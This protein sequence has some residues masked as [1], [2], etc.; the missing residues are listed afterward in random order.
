MRFAAMVCLSLDNLEKIRHNHAL[1]VAQLS[2]RENES[3]LRKAEVYC[4]CTIFCKSVQLTGHGHESVDSGVTVNEG[5]IPD[6][7]RQIYF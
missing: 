6:Y 7:N 1:N 5:K 2:F 3:V 4:N